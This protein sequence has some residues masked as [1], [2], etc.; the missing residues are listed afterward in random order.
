[1]LLSTMAIILYFST[2]CK[3]SVFST[4]VPKLDIFSLC[5]NSQSHRSQVI[6]HCGFDSHFPDN[7]CCLT[8]FISLQFLILFT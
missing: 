8:I 5:D 6:S 2:E 7:L 1:M 4:S 3:D